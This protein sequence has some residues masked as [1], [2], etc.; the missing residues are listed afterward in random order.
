[1]ST[2]QESGT[3]KTSEVTASFK[4]HADKLTRLTDAKQYALEMYENV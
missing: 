4:L 1:M 2:E 3:L